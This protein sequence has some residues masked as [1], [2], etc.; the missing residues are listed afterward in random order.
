M[1]KHDVQFNILCLLTDRNIKSPVELYNFFRSHDF[2]FL[3]FINCFEHDHASGALRSFSVRGE[4]AGEFYI[5]LFDEWF[6]KDFFDVSIRFF[7]DILLYLVDGI[8]ASCC[9]NQ[10]CNSYLVVEHNGDCYPCDFFVFEEWKIGN[11]MQKRSSHHH[12]H[13]AAVRI[14]FPQ[15]GSSRRMQSMP[16]CAHFA[17]ATAPG[18]GIFRKPGIKI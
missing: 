2:K 10:E 7:E 4:E 17:G 8:K 11:L 5:K 16:D 15:S 13:S 14:C 6:K 18:S 1:K 3:Q 12:E 9:Y